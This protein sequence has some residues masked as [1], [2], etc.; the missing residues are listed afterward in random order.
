MLEQSLLFRPADTVDIL[1]INRNEAGMLE[2][3][4]LFQPAKTKLHFGFI[5]IDAPL[6]F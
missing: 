2:Q 5:I 1:A 3:S 4:L 6:I